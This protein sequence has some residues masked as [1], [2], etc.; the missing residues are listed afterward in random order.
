MSKAKIIF[1]TSDLP[2]F[3]TRVTMV[4]PPRDPVCES[5]PAMRPSI[6]RESSMD[7]V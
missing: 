2:D 4:I 7:A 5:Y 3:P 6:H 1:S